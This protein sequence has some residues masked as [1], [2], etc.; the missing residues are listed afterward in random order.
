MSTSILLF[1]LKSRMWKQLEAVMQ[2]R[3]LIRKLFILVAELSV[4]LRLGFSRLTALSDIGSSIGP[5]LGLI[6]RVTIFHSF[7]I[8]E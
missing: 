5:I 1:T 4:G 7:P 3:K 2:V 8:F 6:A